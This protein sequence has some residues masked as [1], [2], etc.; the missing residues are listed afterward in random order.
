M[1]IIVINHF[2]IIK[3]HDIKIPIKYMVNSI[4]KE[5]PF[6]RNFQSIVMTAL[7]NV[8]FAQVVTFRLASNATC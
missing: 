1:V 4:N 6:D 2:V 5:L 8:L 3:Y 7:K